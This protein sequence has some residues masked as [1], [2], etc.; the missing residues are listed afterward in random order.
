[1]Q[2]TRIPIIAALFLSWAFAQN[3]ANQT[4]GK[5]IYFLKDDPHKQWCGYASESRFK[6]QVQSLKAMIVG[7]ADYTSGRIS[8]IQ[9][10]E[11]D[12][13]GDWAVND[14]YMFDANEK[15]QSLKRT[16]NIIPEKQQ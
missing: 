9:V 1:M 16:I 3:G 12:E 2:L 4:T 8:T 15:I 11:T 7:A 13:T 10:T 6:A 5:T 14:E